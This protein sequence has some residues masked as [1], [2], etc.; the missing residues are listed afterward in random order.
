M[1][2]TNSIRYLPALLLAATAATF[3]ISGLPAMFPGSP[4]GAV[5]LG[6]VIEVGTIYAFHVLYRA[7]G[8]H[9]VGI[10]AVALVACSL[11]ALGVYGYL[12][13][14]HVE[15]AAAQSVAAEISASE[16]LLAEID[17]R[18]APT[19]STTETVKHG[20]RVTVTTPNKTDPKEVAKLESQ[21]ST[22]LGTLTQLRK[23][24]EM[25]E[26]EIGP[27]RYLADL[28]G[29]SA[30]RTMELV[31][32]AFVLVLQPFAIVLLWAANHHHGE[33]EIKKKAPVRRRR[34]V[35]RKRTKTP[36]IEHPPALAVVK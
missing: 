19:T 15:H 11:N 6:V 31:I 20:K 9:R 16:N 4:R 1:K 23:R 30:D 36:A 10:L 33:Q 12:T 34:T 29:K 27:A 26:A 18:L 28:I 21:R 25:N 14:A 5:A 2:L 35:K 24:Q 13:K 22:V 8:W 7:R 32:A 3:A 17:R